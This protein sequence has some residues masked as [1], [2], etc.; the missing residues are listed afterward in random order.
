MTKV[1]G[2]SCFACGHVADERDRLVLVRG[3]RQRIFCSEACLWDS[4]R[5]RRAA[6]RAALHWWFSRVALSTILAVGAVTLWHRHRAP[7][8][9]SIS[10]AWPDMPEETPPP[11]GPPVFGPPWPPTDEQWSAVFD[12]TAGIFPL[13]GPTRRAVT[14]DDRI[15]GHEPPRDH[16][17]LCRKDGQCG[18]DLG[19]ELWGEHVYAAFDGIVERVQP[20]DGSEH[21]GGLSVR[22]AHLG[23]MVLTQYFHLAATPRGLGR[24]VAVKAGDVIGLLGDTGLG[25]ARRHLGFALSIRPSK[26]LPEVYWDPTPWMARWPLRVPPHGTVA[27]LAPSEPGGAVSGR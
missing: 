27:G 25:G 12:R 21:R 14:I 26:E 6:R 1:V 11:P 9:H 24:G 4:V 19:G 5:Q 18:V 3:R 17:A 2:G 22:L 13:P 16:L 23:G 15:F 10:Y 20:D 7:E 8:R